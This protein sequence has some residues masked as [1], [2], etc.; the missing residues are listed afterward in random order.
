MT[1]QNLCIACATVQC[2]IVMNTNFPDR[3]NETFKIKCSM[4]TNQRTNRL[5]ETDRCWC[6]GF[7]FC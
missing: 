7:R 1:T 2:S 5:Y 6:Y 3:N 4:I